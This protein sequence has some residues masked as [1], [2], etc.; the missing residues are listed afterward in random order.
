MQKLFSCLYGS[1]LYGTVTPSSDR[2]IKH[3]ILPAIGD[4]LI[5]KKVVNVANHTNKQK[6]VK[7]SVDDV[8]EEFIPIQMFARDFL[9]GQVYALELAFAIDGDQAEQIFHTKDDQVNF[10]MNFFKFTYELREKFLTSNIK[11]MM[12]YVVNQASLYSFKGER[13]NVAR[14]FKE[15]ISS[16]IYEEK[17]NYTIGD[18]FKENPL[19]EKQCIDLQKRYPKYFK[20]STYN[21]G[22][23]R[24]R[25]CVEILEKIFAF[26][27]RTN[28]A[29]K[30]IE[31]I[32]NKYGAR[33]DAASEKNVDWKATMHA[34]R[35]VNEGI[36]ILQNHTLSFPYDKEYID[37][38][39][40]IR[41]GEQ[42]LNEIKILLDEKLE[43]LK[44]LEKT[45]SLPEASIEL[46]AEFDDWL[47]NWMKIYYNITTN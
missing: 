19:F 9:K 37:Y 10:Y 24:Y 27:M 12:G 35:I 43:L 29:I 34:V 8:D 14:E 33:A 46:R 23:G 4:L 11:A 41:R 13:L 7:N 6:N 47:T 20:I 5:G 44:E 40:S 3:I 31:D 16:V 18:A 1:G 42:P 45:T 28:H 17:P 15:I 38:L 32:V 2:D 25:D 30:V 21:I 22:D 39:L 26:T 36:S